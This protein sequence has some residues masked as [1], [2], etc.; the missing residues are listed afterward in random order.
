LDYNATT[1]VDPAVMGALDRACRR[2]WGNP[3][4]LHGA[5]S[6]AWEILEEA[7]IQLGQ[8]FGWNPEELHFCSGG[9][10]AL[11]AAIQG[12]IERKPKRTFITSKTEHG[13]V[14][15][16]LTHARRGGESVVFLGVDDQGKINLPELEAL[17]F[18][19][20]ASPVLVLSPVNHETGAVQPLEAAARLIHGAGGLVLLDGVQAAVRLDPKDW[21][22]FGDLVAISGHKFYAPKGTGL[23]YKKRGVR[24]R[25]RRF[26]GSQEGGLF[27]GTENLPG[28]AAFGA[29]AAILGKNRRDEQRMLATLTREGLEIL[30]KS[31]V[32]VVRESP[33]DA[34]P[35]VLCLSLPW[36]PD[37]EQLLH[38]LNH[39]QIFVSRFSACTDGVVGPSAIL[40][41]MGVPPDRSKKSLRISL[42][43]WSRR[44]DFFRLARA[45]KEFKKNLSLG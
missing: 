10:E 19:G 35:G 4:S 3:S 21:V 32:E 42:G 1:P 16:P 18:R 41:A 14:R 9:T 38:H 24:L 40:N 30:A 45:L 6:A 5:G 44:D 25:P 43:R 13:A 29:A 39:Q 27:P 31:G 15:R 8:C 26:G 36:C 17:L 22:P 2:G 12:L 7:R 28:I 34:A 23:L 33:G 37:M 20:K 11:G